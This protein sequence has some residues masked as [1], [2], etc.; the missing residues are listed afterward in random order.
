MNTANVT[1]ALKVIC[2]YLNEKAAKDPVFKEKLE[3]NESTP[4]GMLEY[5]TEQVQEKA[6]NGCACIEDDEVFGLAVHFI[7]EEMVNS[8]KPINVRVEAESQPTEK[9]KEVKEITKPK[10]EKKEEKKKLNS[11][12]DLFGENSLFNI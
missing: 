4:E 7:D 10:E 5:I 8:K 11:I 1:G 12:S 2:D 3:S 9:P 6:V